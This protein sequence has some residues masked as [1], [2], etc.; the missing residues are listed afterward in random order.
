LPNLI[1]YRI[2]RFDAKLYNAYCRYIND[3]EKLCE[4]GIDKFVS[5]TLRKIEES[6]KIGYDIEWGLESI[7]K[8]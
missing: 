6:K 1:Y 2:K 5:R 4:N 7:Y 3:T 8:F